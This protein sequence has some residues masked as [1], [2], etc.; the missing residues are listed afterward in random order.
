MAN[1]RIYEAIIEPE[2][3]PDGGTL[4]WN[5]RCNGILHVANLDEDT[6]DEMLG[7]DF[8][9]ELIEM[10]LGACDKTC[11]TISLGPG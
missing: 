11:G 6:Y 10:E 1:Y 7:H 9:E 3:S 8:S 5:L 4:V 2:K